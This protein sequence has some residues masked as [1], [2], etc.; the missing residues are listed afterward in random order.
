MNFLRKLTRSWMKPP[1]NG[2]TRMRPLPPFILSAEDE[3]TKSDIAEAE[4][5]IQTLLNQTS[6]TQPKT[7]NDAYIR[8][9]YLKTNQFQQQLHQQQQQ[10]QQMNEQRR[11][12]TW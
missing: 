5:D 6:S 10:L 4:K 1:I 3:K 8:A 2:T 11:V 7:L 12:W 9:T